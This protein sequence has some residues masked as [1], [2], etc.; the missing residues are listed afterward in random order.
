MNFHILDLLHWIFIFH[1]HFNFVKC[2]RAEDV[3]VRNRGRHGHGL[4]GRRVD[5]SAQRGDLQPVLGAL[6]R[7]LLQT[8][9]VVVVGSLPRRTPLE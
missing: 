3:V 6:R 5:D 7:R 8:R 2:R 4:S 1:F 9:V